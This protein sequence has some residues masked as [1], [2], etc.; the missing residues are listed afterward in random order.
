MGRLRIT[1]E[2]PTYYDWDG[3]NALLGWRDGKP[4]V[5]GYVRPDQVL[6]EIADSIAKR[7]QEILW[8]ETWQKAFTG[9]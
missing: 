4:F 3:G 9:K 2:G 8:L 5:D 6:S 7:K 1:R